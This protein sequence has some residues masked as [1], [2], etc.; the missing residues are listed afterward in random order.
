[1]AINDWPLEDR[2][3]EKLIKNGE[4]TLSDSE[5]LA[6]IL[7]TG[8]KGR[9]ALDLARGILGLFESFRGIG[10]SELRDW[11]K[12]AGLGSKDQQDKSG[13][14]IARRFNEERARENR[15]KIMSSGDVA[16]LLMPRMQD[17]KIEVFKV[18]YLNSQ[19]RVIEIAEIEEGS[20]NQARPIIREVFQQALR[21][22]ASSLI[23]V[24]N[25]PSGDPQPSKE[26]KQFTKELFAAGD[27][28]A[29]KCL[30]HIIIGNG[31]FFSFS[32]KGLI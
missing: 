11:D 8:I 23:C 5:L 14:R 15:L 9:S 17:L 25:H 22:F 21:I 1:M 2:P 27:A 12:L 13:Y 19:N 24:H 4:H 26:D 20:V 31:K 32:D 16:R 7:G 6:I 3:R 29:I 10:K 28:L 18:L 30:D